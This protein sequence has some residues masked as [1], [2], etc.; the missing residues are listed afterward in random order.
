VGRTGPR[1]V[2]G[3][4]AVGG[5]GSGA[6]AQQV[7]LREALHDGRR[8][9]AGTR[10]DQVE[11]G[12][13]QEAVTLVYRR[14]RIHEHTHRPLDSL[15]NSLFLSLSLSVSVC[16]PSEQGNEN[17]EVLDGGIGEEQQ[18]ERAREED[19][20]ATEFA[21]DLQQTLLRGRSRR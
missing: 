5:I 11:D 2:N 18:C 4:A 14:L 20:V 16:L 3:R 7:L 1:T 10:E 6:Y 9:E 17:L 21:E 12:E 15:C 19:N 8:N 13:G